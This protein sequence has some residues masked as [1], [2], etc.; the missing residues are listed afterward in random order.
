[1]GTVTGRRA[2]LAWLPH[3]ARASL[4]PGGSS[5]HMRGALLAGAGWVRHSSVPSWLLV[6]APST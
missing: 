2:G 6:A 3:T 4:A 1:M 5:Q